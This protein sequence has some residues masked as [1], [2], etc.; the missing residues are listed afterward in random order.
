MLAAVA[1]TV[2]DPAPVKLSNVDD[3]LGKLQFAVLLAPVVTAYVIAPPPDASVG[4]V[5]AALKANL[6]LVPKKLFDLI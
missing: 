3:A 5:V 6:L 4:T 1:I 2:H